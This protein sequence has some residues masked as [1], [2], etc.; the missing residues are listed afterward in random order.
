MRVTRRLLAG[1]LL[2]AGLL[3]LGGC[4]AGLISGIASS[5]GGN[6]GVPADVQ[7]PQ[8]LAS[9]FWPLAPK[10]GDTRSVVV[11]NSQLA[12]RSVEVLIERV[13]A[14]GEVVAAAK[15][16]NTTAQAQGTSTL[17]TFELDM[18]MIVAGL[19][20]LWLTD[21]AGRL[22]VSVEG[23]DL[24][25]AMPITLVRQPVASFRDA[26]VGAPT[27]LSPYGQKVFIEVDGLRSDTTN[28]I[29]IL[30][31]TRDP[32]GDLG[33]GVVRLATNVQIESLGAVSVLSASIPGSTFPDVVGIEVIDAAAGQSPPIA[34]TYY[35]P[36]VA[37]AL[38]GQGPTTGGT[39]L[40]LI[41]EALVPY[42]FST[43]PATLDYSKI[44]LTFNKGERT[45]QL[46]PEDLRLSD[47][48]TSRLSFAMPPAPDGRPGQVDI[49]VKLVLEG[50]V[51][52]FTASQVFLFANPD[53]FYG[54]RGAILDQLPV[55]S[56]PIQLD[57]APRTDLAP[58]FAILTERGGVGYLQLLL[59][60]QNGMFQPFA[61]PRQI[62]N[63]EV[64]AERVPRDLLVGDFDGDEIPDLFVVNEGGSSAV[65]HLV[66]GQERPDPPLGN[67]FTVP[68]AQGSD[69][70]FVADFD[71][72]GLPDVLLMPVATAVAGLLPQVLLARP[73]GDSLPGF[74]AAVDVALGSF[75]Y[76][77][78]EVADFD[79]DGNLDIAAVSG[80]DLV[81]AVAY[82]YGDGT[83]TAATPFSFTVPGYT[84][85][86]DSPA[87]GLHACRDR[88]RQS[89][90][91]VLS[92]VESVA[93][94]SP[95]LAV[96]EQVLVGPPPLAY[97]FQSPDER[98]VFLAPV[99]PIALSLAANLD[100]PASPADPGPIE[101]VVAI[102]G[103][104]TIVSLGLLQL[105][106]NEGHPAFEPV[107]GGIENGTLAGAE[108]PVQIRSLAFD[109]AFPAKQ[110][111]G[112]A[113]AVFIV[114]EV[115]V[116]GA[117]E[118]RL[119][120]RLVT[121]AR[122]G[123]PQLLP[124]DAG[125]TLP[126]T[127]EGLVG[128]D[129]SPISVAA[130]GAVRDLATATRDGPDGRDQITIIVN[131]GFGGFPGLGATMT[132]R[133]LLPASVTLVP[134]GTGM[135]DG[136]VF[137]SAASKLAYWRP[138][139]PDLVVAPE[140]GLTVL[141][142]E[143]TLQGAVG[144]DAITTPLRDLISD[145]T[146]RNADLG[147]GTRMQVADVDGDGVLDLV[148]LM[149]FDLPQLGEDGARLALCR[150][151]ATPGFEEFPFYLP[152]RL[153][154]VH[155][156]TSAFALGDFAAT[157]DGS[158]VLELAIAVP[159]GTTSSSVDGN[160][161]R[162]LRYD[163][164]S[165]PEDARFV[166]SA[167]ASGPQ[168]LL[169]GSK[170]TLA[171]ASDFDSD[172]LVDLLVASPGDR[173]LRFLRNTAVPSSGSVEVDIGAFEEVL[174]EEL[175][176]GVPTWMRLS[177][178]NGDGNPDAVVVTQFTNAA[179]IKSSAI[180]TYLS[181]GAGEFADARFASS[182]R[183]GT[184]DAVLCGDV[185]DWNRDGVPDLFLGWD[186]LIGDTPPVNLRVLFGGTR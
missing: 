130:D 134:A 88:V 114:H 149:S 170:P 78:F 169:A 144:P 74:S 54:P 52:E 118:R 64:G 115:D 121:V 117:R 63:P 140:P 94:T 180:A 178:V 124:P 46:L 29:E 12:G 75:A 122:R 168:V 59:A 96:L 48:S 125:A 49:I 147:D 13:D 175:A 127:V 8:L 24:P 137:A 10:P 184:F 104:P 36:D 98:S 44:S 11:A 92:G 42:D 38:P 146:L 5:N 135:R 2:A 176:D 47:S 160:H 85:N 166:I 102:R 109:T 70:G 183:I 71:G 68:A 56:A 110:P 120:T 155:G 162:F 69:R 138:V 4:G 27:F 91:V 22:S 174:A 84:K 148:L 41:G 182:T 156:N 111:S 53:P 37:L 116:D 60:Q 165:R 158:V 119:S 20:D 105:V 186:T 87:V 108:V 76:E 167:L 66:L 129:F 3:A 81:M 86:P 28:D 57:Q 67:V 112:E 152:S 26:T 132:H 179:G 101:L 15:Q 131:D 95:T 58:D 65:H 100:Q 45:T 143:V 151:K 154:S 157:G 181:S 126:F 113:K 172:G 128:G 14:A 43:S 83:F 99:E 82:G 171:M 89:I 34:D 51:A 153:T 35:R 185:G 61:A 79:D 33:S 90:G 139:D 31:T 163:G 9:E 25:S 142:S 107:S 30:V 32:V 123:E 103:E 177:D 73:A 80:T 164:G 145:S 6:S 77:A 93:A 40:A 141:P 23:E 7:A 159:A 50:V 161:I 72:D 55:A 173:S 133:G 97:K 136:L 19:Q 16:R 1:G 17:V 150:G 39:L 18:T 106:Q 21:F 62:G